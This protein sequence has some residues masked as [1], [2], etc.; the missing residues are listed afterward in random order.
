MRRGATLDPGFHC[1]GN[2]RITTRRLTL[3]YRC[4]ETMAEG[5][6]LATGLE[7]NDLVWAG[8]GVAGPWLPTNMAGVR[9][10]SLDSGFLGPSASFLIIAFVGCM[11]SS[12]SA[13][14]SSIVIFKL[15]P[16]DR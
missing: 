16:P 11:V 4:R 15:V 12:R 7:S 8:A 6:E 5:I 3:R 1:I 13:S 10:P 2:A 14:G 9:M